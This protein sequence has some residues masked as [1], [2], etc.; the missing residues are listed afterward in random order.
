MSSDSTTSDA[1][2]PSDDLSSKPTIVESYSLTVW[3]FDSRT[4]TQSYSRTVVQLATIDNTITRQHEQ[5]KTVDFFLSCLPFAICKLHSFQIRLLSTDCMALSFLLLFQ[6]LSLFRFHPPPC[7]PPL[8]I[9]RQKRQKIENIFKKIAI[10]TN[11]TL[12]CFDW[13]SGHGTR[14]ENGCAGCRKWRRDARSSTDRTTQFGN[15]KKII[16]V[17]TLTLTMTLTLTL[18]MMAMAMAMATTSTDIRHQHHFYH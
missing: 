10:K 6:F 17:T 16:S 8:Q 1:S 14:L 11:Q 13:Q 4:V 12:R 15:N 3:Q 2:I 7:P 9:G 18:M 5:V